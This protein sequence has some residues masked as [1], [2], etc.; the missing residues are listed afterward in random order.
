MN[1]TQIQ[2]Y[3]IYRIQCQFALHDTQYMLVHNCIFILPNYKTYL[4]L[5]NL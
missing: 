5:V 4:L 3:V 1:A 2:Y